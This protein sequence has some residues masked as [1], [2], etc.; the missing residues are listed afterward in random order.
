MLGHGNIQGFDLRLYR[1]L[2]LLGFDGSHVNIWNI[3]YPLSTE[4]FKKIT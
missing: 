1:D 4:F 2:P 3:R